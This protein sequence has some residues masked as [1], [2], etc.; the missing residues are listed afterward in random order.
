MESSPASYI[1]FRNS[2]IPTPNKRLTRRQAAK[3]QKELEAALA[4]KG[5]TWL[6][7]TF[8]FTRNR[9]H[10]RPGTWRCCR[11]QC[12]TSDRRIKWNKWRDSTTTT[13]RTSRSSTR[14]CRSS[15]RTCRSSTRTANFKGEE[16]GAMRFYNNVCPFP[17][18]SRLAYLCLHAFAVAAT[19]GS[20]P[21]KP[22]SARVDVWFRDCRALFHTRSGWDTQHAGCIISHCF[23]H[24]ETVIKNIYLYARNPIQKYSQNVTRINT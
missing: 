2:R 9:R 21:P 10:N 23:Y 22:S 7:S 18:M 17:L 16:A 1:K 6:V 8:L 3:Q 19:H 12:K 13:T 15:T 5:T 14:A 24:V 4:A 11:G 20:P